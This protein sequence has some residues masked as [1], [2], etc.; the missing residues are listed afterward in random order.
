MGRGAKYETASR[1]C[2]K[3]N[4]FPDKEAVLST[5]L[6]TT[7]MAPIKRKANLPEPASA[8]KSTNKRQRIDVRSSVNDDRVSQFVKGKPNGVTKAGNIL[9]KLVSSSTT[10]NEQPA[11]PR[12]GATLLTPLEQRQIQAQA[13]H[14]VLLEQAQSVHS[15]GA[16]QLTLKQSGG[17]EI[18]HTRPAAKGKQHKRFQY[19]KEDVTGVH[20]NG[21]PRIES[22]TYKV[23]L[24]WVTSPSS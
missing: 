14:D 4:P 3:E 24:I 8:P 17:D 15:L 13:T 18:L 12:G 9:S 6:C 2:S 20:E 16:S 23:Y 21:A 5:P 22:L 7:D 10:P 1:K 11:F 19:K